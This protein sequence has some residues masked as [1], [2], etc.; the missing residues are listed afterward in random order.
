MKRDRKP[1]I[2]SLVKNALA[3]GEATTETRQTENYVKSL[4]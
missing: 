4:K 3:L 2:D 1:L